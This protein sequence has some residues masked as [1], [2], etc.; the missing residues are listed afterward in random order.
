MALV[1]VCVG[2]SLGELASAYPNA[3]M[4]HTLPP[5][6][7]YFC[8]GIWLILGIYY[9]RPVFL[10]YRIGPQKV[11]AL[12]SKFLTRAALQLR[13]DLRGLALLAFGNHQSN[14]G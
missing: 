1:H 12:P 7:V 10:G 11:Q 9:R 3:G 13:L 6:L 2:A 4:Y 5:L 14:G 8:D